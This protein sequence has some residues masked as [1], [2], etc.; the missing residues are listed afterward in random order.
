MTYSRFAGGL[1]RFDSLLTKVDTQQAATITAG[2]I[3]PT[4]PNGLVGDVLVSCTP[5]AAVAL[6]GITAPA[7]WKGKW[8]I[9][10]N[11]NATPATNVVTVTEGATLIMGSATFLMNHADDLI[12]FEH[13]GVADIWRELF[14]GSNG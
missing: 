6:T 10:R 12:I 9:L 7:T 8:I 14:R 5:A 3:A 2:V 4:K 13:T 1:S 11:G